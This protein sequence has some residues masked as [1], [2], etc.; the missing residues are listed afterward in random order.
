MNQ[1]QPLPVN[2]TPSSN[3]QSREFSEVKVGKIFLMQKLAYIYFF[4]NTRALGYAYLP[5]C[6][7]IYE[8]DLFTGNLQ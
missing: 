6:G 3:L 7:I 2:Q 4:R 1:V 8:L 5:L